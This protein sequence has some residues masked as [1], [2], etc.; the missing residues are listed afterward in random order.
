MLHLY[1]ALMMSHYC[2]YRGDPGCNQLVWDAPVVL[3]HAALQQRLKVLAGSRNSRIRQD[4][5]M[6]I[7]F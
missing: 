7:S 4:L 6:A 5:Y 3:Q 2:A 1:C